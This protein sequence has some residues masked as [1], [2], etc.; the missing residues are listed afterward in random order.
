MKKLKH[1]LY[2]RNSSDVAPISSIEL[3]E[4]I[5]PGDAGTDPPLSKCPDDELNTESAELPAHGIDG[6]RR[7]L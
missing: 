1:L 7:Y 6:T 5:V 3:A 2:L 4:L